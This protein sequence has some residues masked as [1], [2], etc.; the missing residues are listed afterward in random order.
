MGLG[1]GNGVDYPG[2]VDVSVIGAS[3]AIGRQVAISLVA[4]G[5]VPPTS[6]LQLV[7][8]HDGDS[9]RVLPGFAADLRDAYAE[10]LPEVD[11][12]LCPEDVLADIIIVAAGRA[13][14]TDVR[15]P[16]D[17]TGLA[18]DNA[19]VFERYAR[20]LARY[21]HGEELVLVVTNPVELG[22]HIF[23]E[24]HPRARVLGMGAFLDTL[25]FRREIADDLGVRRQR[26]HGLVLGEHG[27]HMVPCWST[28]SAYGF[29]SPE[30]RARLS[31][32]ARQDDL[33]PGEAVA[34]VA[35]R[36]RGEGTRAALRWVAGL[37]PALRVFVK[38]YVTHLSGAKT[39]VG[40][41]EMISR[42]VE[43][44]QRGQP[45]QAAAQLRLDGEFLGIEGV[46][47]VPALLSNRGVERVDSIAL[48]VD[49]A[50]GVRAAAVH[51]QRLIEETLPS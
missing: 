36:M 19:G 22:V 15:R 34:E 35:A 50:A 37:S 48:Q 32:L 1:P 24:H 46:T 14:P 3:G 13:V 6:R 18:R 9:A 7:G 41:A 2:E 43:T 21:G 42:L 44:M 47:G 30:G 11:V 39:A 4:G 20:A 23:S 51:S 38:P 33:A 8:R 45:M 16:A 29:D 10:T 17:R 28:V 40:T 25:R 27:A 31:A 49:E 12:A 26:V 5:V